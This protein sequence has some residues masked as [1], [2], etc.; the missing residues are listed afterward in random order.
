MRKQTEANVI[1]T[2]DAVKAM[3][4]ELRAWLPS[5]AKLT[6]FLDRTPTIRASV[7]EVQIALL[8]SIALVILTMLLLL[9]ALRPR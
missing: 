2:V 9:A 1:A 3:L 5:D 4:P 6:P 8:I 7:M